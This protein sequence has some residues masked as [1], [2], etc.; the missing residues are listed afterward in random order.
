MSLRGVVRD[1][2]ALLH[3]LESLGRLPADFDHALLQRLA[4]HPHE[5]FD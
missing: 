2:N 5:V 3:T 1:V 4:T